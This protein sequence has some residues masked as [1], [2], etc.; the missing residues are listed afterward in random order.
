ME[1]DPNES[2]WDKERREAECGRAV[3][4]RAERNVCVLYMCAPLTQMDEN[5]VVISNNLW[6][7]RGN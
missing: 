6:D 1:W 4:D 5:H 7:V 3:V 2:D